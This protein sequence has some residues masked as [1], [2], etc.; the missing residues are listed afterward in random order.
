MNVRVTGRPWSVNILHVDYAR[1]KVLTREMDDGFFPRINISFRFRE[2]HSAATPPGTDLP[3]ANNID[4]AVPQNPSTWKL[5]YAY[6]LT[7]Y[8]SCYGF[9]EN[10][11]TSWSEAEQFCQSKGMVL[12][13]TPTNYEWEI[14]TTLFAR[15]PFVVELVRPNSLAFINLFKNKVSFL[16]IFFFFF[17]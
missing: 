15:E 6:C 17:R 2:W 12:L 3:P 5:K 11:N 9:Y 14:I 7:S 1:L 13:S 8:G 10:R 4:W 16:V